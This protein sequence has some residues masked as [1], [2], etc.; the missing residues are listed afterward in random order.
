MLDRG[1]Q[2]LT[3]E[4]VQKTLCSTRRETSPTTRIMLD[5]CVCSRPRSKAA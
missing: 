3:A 1:E 4:T 5:A 2:V